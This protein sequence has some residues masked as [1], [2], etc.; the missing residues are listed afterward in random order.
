MAS[1]Q[2]LGERD[3]RTLARWAASCAERV[4]VLF[5]AEEPHDALV[6][7]ALGR[8][9]AFA[10][11]ESTAAAEIRLRMVAVRA[12][13]LATTPAGAAAARACAQ[14]AAVAHM[15]AHALGAAAYATRAV[16]LA[17]PTDPDAVA[18]ERRWQ[19]SELTAEERSA[20]RR[21]PALGSDASGPLGP[22]LLSGG[23]LGETVRAIQAEVW[24][25]P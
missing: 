4:I 22:G 3:R 24:S 19:L 10:R 17:K 6:R 11:G 20:L 15:G 5:D 14:A 7:D 16:A 12:A 25:A 2:T 1:I 23:I 18:D 13:G 9:W 8:T 21:L